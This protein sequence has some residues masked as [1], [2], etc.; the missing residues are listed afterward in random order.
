MHD[1][2]VRKYAKVLKTMTNNNLR[3]TD[4]CALVRSMMV[5]AC[6][7]LSTSNTTKNPIFEITRDEEA[8]TAQLTEHFISLLGG[9]VSMDVVK[10][11]ADRT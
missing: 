5:H 7:E 4:I 1:R 9:D 8:L 6:L 10:E 11:E 2:E 3:I